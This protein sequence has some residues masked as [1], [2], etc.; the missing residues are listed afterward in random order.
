MVL[1]R[2]KLHVQN[3]EC[4]EA[5]KMLYDKLCGNLFVR[6]P[7]VVVAIARGGLIPAAQLAYLFN[8][9]METI[10]VSSYN[11]EGDKLQAPVVT[12][13]VGQTQ[14]FNNASVLIVDDLWDTGQT[15]EAVRKVLPQAIY[16]TAF[17]KRV[18]SMDGILPGI[19]FGDTL[20]DNWVVFP[21]ERD[22][23]KY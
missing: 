18:D 7:T 5:V 2:P 13:T 4:T 11:E 23:R 1:A 16:A 12:M 15:I 8:C 10:K 20:P 19:V 3:H 9:P 6:P 22:L 21:W 14:R 17:L